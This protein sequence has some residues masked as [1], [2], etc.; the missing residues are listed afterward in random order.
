MVTNEPRTASIIAKTFM[1][2]LAF[3]RKSFL[4]L[5]YLHPDKSLDLFKLFS[6]RLSVVNS[7]LAAANAANA[8]HAAQAGDKNG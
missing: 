5:M 3:E 1:S 2:C 4:R 6:K 8:A 7:R